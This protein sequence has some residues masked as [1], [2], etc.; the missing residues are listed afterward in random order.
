MSTFYTMMADSFGRNL[1]LLLYGIL[2]MTLLLRAALALRK[3]QFYE[4]GEHGV[5]ALI[6]LM[7]GTL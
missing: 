2:S 4:A 5:H 6:Y 7:I 3:R 1:H